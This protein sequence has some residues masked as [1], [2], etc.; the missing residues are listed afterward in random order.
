M[1]RCKV[2]ARHL[3][4]IMGGTLSRSRIAEGEYTATRRFEVD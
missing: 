2:K 4:I 3:G 1:T